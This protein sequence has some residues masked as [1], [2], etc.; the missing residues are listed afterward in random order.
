MLS[1]ERTFSV[2]RPVSEVY[3]YLRDFTN[4]EQWDPGTVRT[5][6]TDDGELKVGAQ[7]HNVSKF[8]GKETELDYVLSEDV[9][10]KHVVFTGEN[11]TASTRDDL[12]VAAQP[13][14]RTE[15]WYVA[16]FEFH[17]LAR[18]AEPLIKRGL[19]KL[20]DETVA[21]MSAVLEGRPV[22]NAA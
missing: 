9:T 1:V 10:D 22:P 20:A 13:D 8:R 12:S 3:A 5:T 18:L 6:R 16:T 21:Q 15:I 11:K 7:F 17:G 19:D 4:T 14:G 2:A